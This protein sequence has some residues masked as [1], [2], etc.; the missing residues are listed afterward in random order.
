VLQNKPLLI[1]LIAFLVVIKFVLL[2]LQQ[3]QQDVYQ[4]LD[5]LTKRVQRSEALIAQQQELLQWKDRQQQ[6]LQ[7]L[8]APFPVVNNATQYRLQLQQ[9]MQLLAAEHKVSVT[10]FDWLSDSP[11]EVFNLYRGRVSLRIEGS[12]ANVMRWHGQLEQQFPQFI[13]RDIRG[14]WRDVLT[15]D[16]RIELNLLIEVDYQLQEGA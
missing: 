9:Q 1:G 5:S 12:A 7:T 2:P 15:A 11:L 13:L 10:F 3:K 16:S 6:Q 14:N 8:L 4:Q